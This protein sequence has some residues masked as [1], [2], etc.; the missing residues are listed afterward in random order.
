MGKK[1][2][3]TFNW[4]N[5]T[6]KTG[7]NGGFMTNNHMGKSNVKT[8]AVIAGSIA[9]RD[10]LMHQLERLL[11]GHAHIEGH[12]ASAGLSCCISADLL[13]ISSQ[14]LLLEAQ[15]WIDQSCPQIVAR[16]AIDSTHLDQLFDIKRSSTVLL[17]NDDRDATS[18]SIE[19]LKRLGIDHI[20]LLPWYPEMD[21][22]EKADHVEKCHIAITL[23]EGELV[24]KEMLQVVDLGPR[25]IDLS[26][27]VEIL[28]YLDLLDEKSHYL[29]ATYFATVVSLSKT[30]HL[31]MAR[32]EQLND[33]LAQVLHQINDGVIAYSKEG[34]IQVFSQK[35]ELI[36]GIRSERAIGRPLTQIIKNDNLLNFLKEPLEHG[37][38]L[39]SISDETYAVEKF[40]TGS[41]GWTVCTFRSLSE[42]AQLNQKRR[43]HHLQQGHIAKYSFEDIRHQSPIMNETI[44][45]AKKIAKT[46]LSILIFG[47]SGTGKELFASAIHRH[48]QVSA[49]PFIGVNF[50]ALSEELVESELFGYE[51]GAFTGAKKGGR[52]GLF[53]QACGGTLFLDEIG[54]ISPKIQTRL[55]RVLQEKEVM[56]IGGTQII[57]VDVRII[58]ATNKPL[59]KL[60]E[61]NQFREDLYYRLKRLSLSTPPLRERREDIPLLLAWFLKKNGWTE[62][63]DTHVSPRLLDLLVSAP[64]KGNV[65]ELESIAE[66]MV[67]VAEG[68][69]LSENN[70]PKDF[71]AKEEASLNMVENGASNGGVQNNSPDKIPTNHLIDPLIL[72]FSS[73]DYKIML[74]T[75]KTYNEKGETIGREKLSK[76]AIEKGINLTEDKIRSRLKALENNDL[77]DLSKGRKGPV[78]LP[79]GKDLL[80]I[81]CQL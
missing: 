58:A 73:P 66:Y 50:S 20:D 21:A 17:V 62:N 2:E 69:Q 1:C 37:E 51:E 6:L 9:T 45:T 61:Q 33:R 16:R 22:A 35:A 27:I 25:I 44:E 57:P 26:T 28:H 76:I 23:G 63:F 34:Q 47:E 3:L 10:R 31:A 14:S 32:Q 68:D 15:D 56:R 53:E 75:I 24:P 60:C 64:W 29:S 72:K 7:K 5:F 54:D 77:I 55:L 46:N 59:N 41:E 8:I 4:D 42:V 39:I 65:R 40:T 79:K 30:I 52:P 80:H 48:S 18:E 49:G 38:V 36:F 13:V 70:L 12:S 11:D 67:A 74:E 71:N 19:L 43:R 81:L 78:L